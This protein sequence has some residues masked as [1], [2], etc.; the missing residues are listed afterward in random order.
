MPVYYIGAPHMGIWCLQ[1]RRKGWIPWIWSSRWLWASACMLVTTLRP[2]ARAAKDL[3]HRTAS[4][5]QWEHCF[6]LV[7]DVWR[8]T[9]LWAVLSLCCGL[10]KRGSWMSQGSKPVSSMTPWFLL[11]RPASSSCLGF[12]HW[13]NTAHKLKQTLFFSS[14]LSSVFYHRNWKRDRDTSFGSRAYFGLTLSTSTRIPLAQIPMHLHK[15][16]SFWCCS[17]KLWH[18]AFSHTTWLITQSSFISPF[19]MSSKSSNSSNTWSY[20]SKSFS[21]LL[22]YFLNDPNPG[23]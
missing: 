3:K 13:W 8:S 21:F 23:L 10:R 1:G 7:T 5:A 6:L 20:L 15:F 18:R 9:L 11:Q 4:A 19:P 17:Y 22:S 12:A 14:F 2:S 16:V